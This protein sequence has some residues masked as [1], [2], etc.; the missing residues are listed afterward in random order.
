M[1]QQ[2]KNPHI[3]KNGRKRRRR[4]QLHLQQQRPMETPLHH[5][6]ASHS[7]TP[8]CLAA[9]PLRGNHWQ[10]EHVGVTRAPQPLG[11]TYQS[12][13]TYQCPTRETHAWK[14][15]STGPDGEDVSDK[16]SEGCGKKRMGYKNSGEA[17][18]GGGTGAGICSATKLRFGNHLGLLCKF[19]N[20]LSYEKQLMW[21]HLQIFTLLQAFCSYLIPFSNTIWLL[22]MKNDV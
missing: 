18:F 19:N 9:V 1:N 8:P 13:E 3:K 21:K 10:T 15:V 11:D 20:V 16:N 7:S 5:V 2:N 12:W 17:G 14:R 6:L 22:L 4:Y